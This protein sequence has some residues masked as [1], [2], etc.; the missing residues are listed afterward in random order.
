[1]SGGERADGLAGG[2]LAGQTRRFPFDKLEMMCFIL[3]RESRGTGQGV[4]NM[5]QMDLHALADFVLVASHGGFGK[6]SRSSGRSKATL[7]RK[8]AELEA[9]LQVRLLERG[10]HALRLTDQG[11]ALFLRTRGLLS[12]L[13]QAGDDIAS[14]A[15]LLAGSLRVSAPVLLAHT[16][17]GAI[18]AAFSRMHPQ[19]RIEINAEDRFVDLVDEGY[20]IV[21]RTNPKPDTMIGR[22][23][24]TD[25]KLLV[26]PPDLALPVADGAVLPAVL[27]S[28]VG[29]VQPWLVMTESGQRTF[30]PDPILRFSSIL[31]VHDAV[32]AGAGVASLPLSIVADDLA[33]GRLVSWGAMAGRPVEVW[34][35]HSAQRLASPKVTGFVRFLADQFH[36]G[37]LRPP[38]VSAL[39][40]GEDR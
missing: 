3:L 6:A 28:R 25:R 39:F 16:S 17:L 29:E 38:T 33:T 12:E 8:V 19:L 15:G 14:G 26:A 35:L 27:L 32:R 34:A 7:S 31:L 2:A 21:I 23:L 5:E 20:D 24:L 18:A 1:M 13:H 11:E 40:Q 10:R 37:T 36:D 30:H 22:R 9:A 4:L